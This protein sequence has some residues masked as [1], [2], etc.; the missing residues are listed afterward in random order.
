MTT[1]SFYSFRIFK[2]SPYINFKKFLGRILAP[3]SG[4][5]PGADA[6]PLP[7]L[8]T[9]LAQLSYLLHIFRPLCL[10]PLACKSFL[11]PVSCTS[12]ISCTALL[13]HH[14][15]HSF[16]IPP[17]LTILLYK[18]TWPSYPIPLLLEHESTIRK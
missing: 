7:P 9:P 11:F 3:P 4:R 10:V 2:I 18:I 5:R 1:F 12:S 16:L 15:Q 8:A 17:P 13:P 6:P 14:Q